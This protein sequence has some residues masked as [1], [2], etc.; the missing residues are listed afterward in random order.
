[1]ESESKFCVDR[2]FGAEEY[3]TSDSIVPLNLDG[4]REV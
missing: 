3:G 1:L 4:E 2:E